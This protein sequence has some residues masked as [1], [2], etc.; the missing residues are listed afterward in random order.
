MPIGAAEPLLAGR[1]VEVA[2]E[3]ADVDRIAPSPWAPSSRTGA[4]VAASAA[5]SDDLPVDPGHVR[6]G[7]EPGASGHGL[8][9][10]GER[11]DA[12]AR[13]P[14]ARARRP[15]ARAGRG[16]PRRSSA[17][18][19]P[20]RRSR[21]RSTAF[22]PSVVERVSATSPGVA[23]EQRGQRGAQRRGGSRMTPSKCDL[24]ARPR[25]AS[26]QRRRRGL[27]RRA[28]GPARRCRRSGR[29]RARGLGTRSA[30]PSGTPR[31]T[32]LGS[33]RIAHDRRALDASRLAL[34]RLP[35]GRRAR[36]ARRRSSTPAARPEPLLEAIE[37]HGV[38]VTHLLL[39]HH[40]HDHVA[41]NHVYKERF[42]VEILAHPLEAEHLMDVD[43]TIEPGA[44]RSRSGGSLRRAAHARAHGRDALLPRERRAR[45]SPATRC[46]RARWAACAP[47]ARPASRTCGT[48]SWTC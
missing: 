34:E 28:W 8:G 35:G 41:E 42:G 11:R 18:S 3:L 32:T 26:A 9:E 23:A 47:P 46:S 40:H 12:D 36:R 30:G 22:T 37:Q 2:A 5:A 7:H 6:A 39:T 27:D 25:V 4:P 48:R 17:T 29:P 20:G 43:R 16:A 1:G 45:S 13:R 24:P 31:R 10:L 15:A 38:D 19:S 33:D 21:P 44:R 14:A